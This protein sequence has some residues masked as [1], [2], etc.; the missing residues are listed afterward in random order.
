[1]A[2][3]AGSTTIR[4]VRLDGTSLAKARAILALA[5]PGAP[6]VPVAGL[7]MVTVL[8]VAACRT[9]ARE[10]P[11]PSEVAA[12][13]VDVDEAPPIEPE[14]P[15]EDPTTLEGQRDAIVRALRA[16]HGISDDAAL[17]VRELLDGSPYAGWGNPLL[18]KHP[19]SRAE[20]R[21]RRAKEAPEAPMSPI[22]GRPHM[23]P[24]YDPRVGEDEGQAR[25]CIDRFEFPGVPCEYPVVYARASEAAALCQAVGKR[26]CDAHEWEGACAGA[27]EPPES[28]YDFSRDRL[29]GDHRHNQR[30][31]LTWAYGKERDARACAT[32]GTRSPG[33]TGDWSRCGTHSYP[34]GSFPACKSPFGVYDLHGN[35]A[36]HMSRPLV[37]GELGGGGEGGFT[38]MKGSWFG[39]GGKLVHEDDCR[40]RAPSWHETRVSNPNS[41]RNDHLG[42]RCCLDAPSPDGR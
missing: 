3:R 20:C 26:L 19:I 24:L 35:V 9:R 1:M 25:V 31:E 37:P 28:A 18:S 7:V 41:H 33:C 13:P 4:G 23:A 42:F 12:A 16:G 17:R 22:C 15:E 5:R 39:F 32:A 11:P 30:R 36:E 27:L 2:S 8:G 21:A 38:E 6:R 10:E 29:Q 34:T 40:W 14:E